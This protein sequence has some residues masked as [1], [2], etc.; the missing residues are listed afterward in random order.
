MTETGGT[1]IL[2][3]GKLHDHAVKRIAGAFRMLTV[4]K[5]DADL[6]AAEERQHVRGMAA[7]TRI[8]ASFLE[9]VGA[10]L[11]FSSG[12]DPKLPG[13]KWITVA[14]AFRAAMVFRS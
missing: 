8:D 11:V 7:M 3:P 13:V 1:T 10:K 9:R 6:L 14:P 2:V 12:P 4:G 5:A